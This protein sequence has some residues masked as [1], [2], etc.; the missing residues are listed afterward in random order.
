MTPHDPCRMFEAPEKHPPGPGQPK[1]VHDTVQ[2]RHR[3]EYALDFANYDPRSIRVA[4]RM[5]ET[6][7]S[8]GGFQFKLIPLLLQTHRH[9][10]VITVEPITSNYVGIEQGS[11]MLATNILPAAAAEPAESL[12][13][14]ADIEQCAAVALAMQ[15]SDDIRQIL[16]AEH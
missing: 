2:T 13:M 5:F 10:L 15:L 14:L 7:E 1:L 8:V 16:L 12:D 3:A 6:G 9:F 4:E 11:I